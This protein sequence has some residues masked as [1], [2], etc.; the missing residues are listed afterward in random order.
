MVQAP[1]PP[2]NSYVNPHSRHKKDTTN[3]LL[4]P[5]PTDLPLPTTLRSHRHAKNPA[6]GPGTTNTMNG[7]QRRAVTDRMIASSHLPRHED[8]HADRTHVWHLILNHAPLARL[9]DLARSGSISGLSAGVINSAR[10]LTFPACADGKGVLSPH[11]RIKQQTNPP[12]AI[13]SSDT[14]G[15]V[16]PMST[17]Q[18]RHIITF[19]DAATRFSISIPIRSRA[20]LAKLIPDT[21]TQIANLQCT[22]HSGFIPTTRGNIMLHV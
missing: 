16:N 1:T 11:P 2:E 12:A 20:Q 13:I 14:D 6:T 21:L 3:L 8:M 15:P 5:D 17:L 7:Q 19:L 10:P 22:T 9:L 4:S 18:H